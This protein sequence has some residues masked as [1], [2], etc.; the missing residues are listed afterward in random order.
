MTIQMPRLV[1]D[2]WNRTQN[3]RLNSTSGNN[4]RMLQILAGADQQQQQEFAPYY[5]DNATQAWVPLTNCTQFNDLLRVLTCYLNASVVE[6]NGLQITAALLASINSTLAQVLVAAEV[7]GRAFEPPVTTTTA[8]THTTASTATTVQTTT[9]APPTSVATTPAPT[10]R[11]AG[12][13]NTAAII[14]GAVVGSVLVAVSTAAAVLYLRRTA[15]SALTEQ[16]ARRDARSDVEMSPL[17]R[18]TKAQL[19]IPQL[20]VDA[21]FQR[22]AV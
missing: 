11:D 15:G 7:A 12:A 1:A 13:N 2:A 9:P 14:A 17:L 4:R 6:Q 8:A 22:L 19:E 21:F 10:G 16:K 18:T 3:A 5:L 20:Q